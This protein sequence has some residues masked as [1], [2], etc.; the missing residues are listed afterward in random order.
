MVLSGEVECVS[1]IRVA[2]ALTDHSAFHQ[3][4]DDTGIGGSCGNFHQRVCLRG[5]SGNVQTQIGSNSFACGAG[6][7]GNRHRFYIVPSQVRG[8]FVGRNDKNLYVSCIRNGAVHRGLDPVGQRHA[9]PNSVNAL[10]VKLHDLVVPVDLKKLSLYADALGE[11]LCHVGVKADPLVR[12]VFLIIHRREI[13]DADD[14]LAL[15]LDVFQIAVCGSGRISGSA[16]RS[17]VVG[18]RGGAAAGE[19]GYTQCAC[20]EQ[21]E[22]SLGFHRDILLKFS[23]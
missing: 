16:V 14:Q 9:V 17:G 22:Q 5:N 18:L 10:A 13:G 20:G 8:C 15:A 6:L 21:R 23:G 19:H 12:A 3:Q 7:S 11:S 4:V 1:K 2:G